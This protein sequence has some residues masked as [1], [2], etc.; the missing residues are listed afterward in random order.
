MENDTGARRGDR[1]RRPEPVEEALGGYV[2]IAG[3]AWS[4]CRLGDR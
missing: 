3:V 4:R 1:E 2:G